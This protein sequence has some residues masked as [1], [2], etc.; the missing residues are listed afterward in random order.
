MSTSGAATTLA[1][2]NKLGIS[3]YLLQ[4]INC[5]DGFVPRPRDLDGSP[6]A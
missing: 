3:M 5:R 4:A 2:Q 6:P 1:E